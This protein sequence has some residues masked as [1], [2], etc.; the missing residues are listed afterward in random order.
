M[1]NHFIALLLVAANLSF[2]AAVFAEVE[3]FPALSARLFLSLVFGQLGCL[4]AWAAIGR[5][6]LTFRTVSSLGACL[7]FAVCMSKCSRPSLAEWFCVLSIY[8]GGIISCMFL[9]RLPGL[10]KSLFSSDIRAWQYTIAGII[11][12]TTCVA[13]VLGSLQWMEFPWAHPS[14]IVTYSVTFGAVGV[15]LINAL[16]SKGTRLRFTIPLLTVVTATAVLPLLLANGSLLIMAYAIQAVVICTNW[17]LWRL[18]T[19]RQDVRSLMAARSR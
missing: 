17:T 1:P 8:V 15:S 2:D 11:G 13:I 4:A 10:L 18:A 3:P 6:S 14:E 5:G 7:L 16:A 12:L 9:L 19:S